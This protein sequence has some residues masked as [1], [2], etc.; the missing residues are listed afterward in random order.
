LPFC[1]L[2]WPRN[3]LFCCSVCPPATP[4]RQSSENDESCSKEEIKMKFGFQA[5]SAL[6][7]PFAILFIVCERPFHP[8]QNKQGRHRV[9]TLLPRG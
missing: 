2:L 4:I 6:F 1:A 8:L 9:Y 7:L 3:P 5:Y